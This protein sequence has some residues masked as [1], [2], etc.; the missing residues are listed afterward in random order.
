MRAGLLTSSKNTWARIKDLELGIMIIQE[1]TDKKTWEDFS[2]TVQPHTFLQSWNWGEVEKKLGREILRLGVYRH[3][4]EVRLPQ[5]GLLIAVALITKIHARRGSFLFCP[6]GPILKG[7]QDVADVIKELSVYLKMLGKKEGFDFIRISPLFPAN[8]ENLVLFK[9]NGFRNAPVHMMHP[10]LAWLLNIGQAEGELLQGMRKTTRY[11]IKRAEK[12][13]SASSLQGGIEVTQSSEP[14]D[15]EKFWP[16]YE[17][18]VKRQQFSPFPKKTLSAEFDVLAA[19]NQAQFF[20]AHYQDEIVAAAIIIFYGNSAFYHHAASSQRFANLN[21]TYLLQWRAIQEAKKR[22]LQFY[23]FW[24]VVS[25]H[26][27]KHPWFGLSQF[28]KGFGGTAEAYVHAQ[29]LPLSTKY[30]FSYMVETVRRI[31]RGL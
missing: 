1:I 24:G 8:T 25:D 31:K 29:D 23:N 4:A 7:E 14:A 10:E 16:V 27:I 13:S 20:F 2:T 9:K 11:C 5:D 21:T 18:T 30:W 26:E 28:K 15:I 22:G 19:D 17:E 3:P 6:Q 12:D